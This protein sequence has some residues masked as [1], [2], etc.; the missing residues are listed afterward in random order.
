MHFIRNELFF[1]FYLDTKMV[2]EEVAKIAPPN[3]FHIVILFPE[4]P[5]SEYVRCP[6][7]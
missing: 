2:P 7:T 4:P 5:D 6:Y 3:P 1:I